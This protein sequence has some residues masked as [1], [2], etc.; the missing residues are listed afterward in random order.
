MPGM[1]DIRFHIKSVKQ[2]RQITNAMRLVSAAR[3]RRALAGIQR[4]RAYFLHAL[5]IITDI[6]AHT[7]EVDHPYIHGRE[8]QKVAYIVVAGDRGLSGSYN[9]DAISLAERGMEG[10]QIAKLFTVGG[11]ATLHFLRAELK[12][13]TRFE[14]LAEHPRLEEARRFATILTE[15]YDGGEIDELH[16]VYTHF[17]S[18]LS[19]RPRDHRLLP[20][21]LD[22]FVR[23]EYPGDRP[24]RME[25]LYDPSPEQV[26]DAMISQLIVGFLYGAMVHSYASENCT[27]MTAMENATHS[28]DELIEKLTLRYNSVR[29]LSITNELADIVGAANAANAA[30]AAEQAVRAEEYQE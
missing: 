1:S 13:D 16:I 17:D 20:I 6:R 15:M 10:R 11:V 28:A 3:M 21:E 29:Q 25:I 24:V 22:G 2:T 18:T 30:R 4:N 7:G 14:R 23:A 8:G 26:L 12:P 27:R 9:R 5:D 19:H